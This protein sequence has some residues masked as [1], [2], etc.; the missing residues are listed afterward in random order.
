MTIS[1]CK[2]F[3]CPYWSDGKKSE[4]G[5]TGGYGCT[6]FSVASHCP[7]SQV[8]NVSSTEYELFADE[9][10]SQN[11]QTMIALGISHLVFRDV[12]S[13]ES[14]KARANHIKWSR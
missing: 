4:E 11:C 1:V 3:S 14:R 12:E 7:V 10:V 9:G 2:S 13:S 6:M 8:K 5:I